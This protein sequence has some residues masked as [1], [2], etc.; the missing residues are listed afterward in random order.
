M[1]TFDIF[2]AFSGFKPNKSKCE[3]AGLGDL[4]GVKSALCGMECIDLMF[5]VI[6]ILGV[7]NSYHKNFENQ[8]NFINL[9]LKIGKHLRLWRMQ[10]LSIPGK[11]T[12][13]K[14]IAIST[15]VH[16]ALVKVTPNSII[17]ELDKIK[18]HFI[19]QNGN[20][21]IKQGTPCKD[22]ENG[23]LKNVDLTFKIISLQCSW[24]KQLYD[25]STHD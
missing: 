4:K 14:T 23:G 13:F 9:V 16:L 2:P 12:I 15:I 11:T 17:L 19:W 10:N 21:K 7:Y 5:N 22:Y 3:I 6:K 18:K 1:K 20:P 25:S 8:E 24:V